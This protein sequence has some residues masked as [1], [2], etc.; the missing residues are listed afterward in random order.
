MEK[1]KLKRFLKGMF[2]I[3]C[4]AMISNTTFAQ[5]IILH[6]K[7]V[8]NN[9]EPLIGA[10][11]RIKANPAVAA[12]A[13]KSGDFTLPVPAGTKT[14][15]VSY[16]GYTTTDIAVNTSQPNLGQIPIA[17]DATSLSG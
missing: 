3:F 1:L 11:I 7:I 13:N 6:G 9:G 12:V 14:V 16:I 17:P 15:T 10:T 5:N 4:F 8:D 2:L